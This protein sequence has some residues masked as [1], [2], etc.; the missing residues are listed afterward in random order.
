[1]ASVKYLP[2]RPAMDLFCP[3]LAYWE[4]GKPAT[5]QP[6]SAY[7]RLALQSAV[8]RNWRDETTPIFSTVSDGGYFTRAERHIGLYVQEL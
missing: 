8:G 3:T 7:S 1:M 5:P 4:F 2:I 6:S